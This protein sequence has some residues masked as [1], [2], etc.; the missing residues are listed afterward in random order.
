MNQ[1]R[2]NTK[3]ILLLK[4]KGDI[5]KSEHEHYRESYAK[6]LL[7]NLGKGSDW[8]KMNNL[9]DLALFLDLTFV[10]KELIKIYNETTNKTLKQGI[11]DLHDGL[12]DVS[13]VLRRINDEDELRKQLTLELESSQSPIIEPPHRFD[14][15]IMKYQANSFEYRNNQ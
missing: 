10:K 8:F 11:K 5:A 4:T 13:D 9:K 1:P 15:N 12:L 6:L 14:T 7:N 2:H 3:Q